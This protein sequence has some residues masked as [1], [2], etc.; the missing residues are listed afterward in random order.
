VLEP[1]RG[2]LR[3]NTCLLR[4]TEH[5]RQDIHDQD[6][7]QGRE[8]VALAQ[9]APMMECRPGESVDEHPSSG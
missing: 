3:Q 9:T 6:K 5:G 2:N 8:G 7:E 1:K 4:G